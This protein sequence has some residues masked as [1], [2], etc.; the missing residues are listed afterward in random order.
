[1]SDS[2]ALLDPIKEN[3]AA[4]TNFIVERMQDSSFVVREAAGE[5]VGRFAENC[6]DDFL[7]RHQQ[8]IPCLIKVV[9]DLTA[10]K[11]ELT[12]TKT[13]FALNEFIQ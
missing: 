5:T 7:D 10:S 13:I 11:E 12:I 3:M 9:Q 6:G 4:L 2:D 8:V 1:M